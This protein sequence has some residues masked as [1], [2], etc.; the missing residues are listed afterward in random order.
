MSLA[1]WALG[2]VA[3]RAVR[4]RTWA[5]ANV[6]FDPNAAADFSAPMIF[7]YAGHGRDTLTA[8]RDILG[9]TRTT[10][11]FEF[12]VPVKVSVPRGDGA[13]MVIDTDKSQAFAFAG[14]WRQCE[15]A[16]L[17]PDDANPWGALW[18][19]FCQGVVTA[20]RAAELYET[21]KGGRVAARLVELTVD[22]VSDPDIGAAPYGCWADLLAAMRGDTAEVAAIADLVE[23][24]IVGGAT[25]PQWQVDM[26]SLGISRAA[27]EAIG[28][29]PLA[30]PDGEVVGL[31]TV[32]LDDD[33]IEAPLDPE[34]IP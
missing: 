4:G 22:T 21:D 2:F 34:T 8:S 31:E 26:T 33:S 17:K 1:A 23:A 25:L 13:T 27:M 9:A 12:Y 11:R 28:L 16:L 15:I 19:L 7:V 18:R 32:E 6:F 20:E 5:G 10:V 3:A 29:A 24:L 30:T 14:L